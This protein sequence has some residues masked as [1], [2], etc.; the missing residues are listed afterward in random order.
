M[1]S[2]RGEEALAA[3][4]RATEL[5]PES[6]RY[7]ISLAQQLFG[8]ARAEEAVYVLRENLRRHP[9]SPRSYEMIARY[10]NQLGQ[11]AEAMAFLQQGLQR[12]P[13]NMMLRLR[14]CEQHWQ[15]W[16]LDTAIPCLES[17]LEINPKDIEGQIQ[18]AWYREDFDQVL[19]LTEAAVEQHPRSWYRKMQLCD[20]LAQKGEWE[21]IIEV[22]GGAFPQL[23]APDPQINDFTHWPAR[24]LAE[25]LL[26][27]GQKERAEVLINA[28]LQWFER[29][30]RLQAGGWTS[31]VDDALFNALLGRNDEA[32]SILERAVNRDWM[33]FARALLM[34]TSL[35][36]VRD[37]PRFRG[38]IERLE[39][40]MAR[41]RK[42]LE[43]R[44]G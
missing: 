37:D 16:D 11:P 6:S 38:L 19:R 29:S 36:D 9:D 1:L 15:L 33:F 26:R 10:L 30:R 5:D 14:V 18:L 31:G 17:Y 42:S 40:N 3:I 22:A 27:T 7:Q 44:K 2:G 23:L 8:L 41:E 12:D 39:A 43:A 20:V 32:L 28:S 4:R 21:R 34:D 24:R 25:A 35:A 13:G